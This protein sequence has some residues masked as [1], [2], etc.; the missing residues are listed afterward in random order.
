MG[1]SNGQRKEKKLFLKMQGAAEE[2]CLSLI[3]LLFILF[4]RTEGIT[5]SIR[6]KQTGL[7]M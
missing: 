3:S 7:T 2:A 6:W 1:L 4:S 5:Q